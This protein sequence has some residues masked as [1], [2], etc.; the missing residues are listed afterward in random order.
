MGVIEAP[1]IKL[2]NGLTWH[3]GKPD[4]SA[5]G[6]PILTQTPNSFIYGGRAK[7]GGELRSKSTAVYL[8][9]SGAQSNV[10]TAHSKRFAC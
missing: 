5:N 2:R 10:V 7:A 8:S 6:S 3:Q 4:L 9:L 1:R